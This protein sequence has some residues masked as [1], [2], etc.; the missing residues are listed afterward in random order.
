MKNST[1]SVFRNT[2]GIILCLA[3]SR[4]VAA[5]GFSYAKIVPFGSPLRWEFSITNG[6]DRTVPYKTAFHVDSVQ[7]NGLRLA[8]V[9]SSVS[10][11]MVEAF[12][13]TNLAFEIPCSIYRPFSATSETFR[14]SAS[15][16]ALEAPAD[17]TFEIVRSSVKMLEVLPVF[18]SRD[19]ET[20]DG[21]FVVGSA[22]TNR[23]D[24]PVNIRF[25]MSCSSEFETP[26]GDWHVS[27][28]ETNLLPGTGLFVSTL[29]VANAS[30]PGE[31]SFAL[32]SD[33]FPRI[34]G[35][36]ATNPAVGGMMFE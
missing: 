9:A 7:Y 29:I 10:T 28:N 36:I 27:W 12:S 6:S 16:T 4:G 14:C 17:R 18:L 11:N 24:F 30:T 22:W 13:T 25:S 23:F 34:I 5:S 33:Q 35:N 32:E 20:P 1:L 21:M 3:C 15:A 26:N 2:A 19:P 8:S 31:L